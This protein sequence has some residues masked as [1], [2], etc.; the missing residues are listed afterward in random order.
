M[1]LCF[2]TKESFDLANLLLSNDSSPASPAY[3]ASATI[4][5][6]SVVR[7]T[8]WAVTLR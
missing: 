4:N 8:N 1:T 5:T 6:G 2:K 7:R 3:L